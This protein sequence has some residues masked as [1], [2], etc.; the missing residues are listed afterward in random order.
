ME[1]PDLEKRDTIPTSVKVLAA[2]A[3]LSTLTVTL[4]LLLQILLSFRGTPLPWSGSYVLFFLLPLQ[5]LSPPDV[6][7]RLID[8][9]GIVV[10]LYLARGLLKLKPTAWYATMVCAALLVIG[11]F[12]SHAIRTFDF[13]VL[14]NVPAAWQNA[15]FADQ[16]TSL[17][18]LPR[19]I[20]PILAQLL[21]YASIAAYLFEKRALFG[22]EVEKPQ[23]MQSRSW[24]ITAL[25]IASG[26]IAFEQIYSILHT[27][28]TQGSAPTAWFLGFPLPAPLDGFFL[29]GSIALM[30]YLTYGLIK[31][32]SRALPL[33]WLCFGYL[34]LSHIFWA[35]R[36]I[37]QMTGAALEPLVAWN[38]IV[39]NILMALI[40]ILVYVVVALYLLETK[41]RF[42]QEPSE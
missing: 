32:T 10:C 5:A 27:R 30:V 17:A 29:L 34:I 6:L 40:T 26:L 7:N 4:Q 3:G 9:F 14:K 21:L 12:V 16:M 36:A 25:G 37:P 42:N 2:I 20:L 24:E 41:E 23:W 22:V 15:P 8:L 11:R 1:N 19:D 35:V 31:L 39:Q 28:I 38:G 33:A 18:N 13:Y